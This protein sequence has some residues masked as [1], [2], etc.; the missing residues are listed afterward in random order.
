MVDSLRPLSDLAAAPASEAPTSGGQTLPPRQDRKLYVKIPSEQD[1][2]LRR[3]GLIL[4]M[5]PGHTPMVIWCEQERKRLG[6]RCLLHEGLL[7]ELRELLGDENV[8]LK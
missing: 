1:P 7:L 6:A 4:N 8:V 5:F 3:I 2:L